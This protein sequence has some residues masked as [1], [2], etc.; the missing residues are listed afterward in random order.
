MTTVEISNGV[1][2][3]RLFVICYS[4]D[5]ARSDCKKIPVITRHHTNGWSMLGRR[6]N[7]AAGQH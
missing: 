7:Y 6:H 3:C 1:L 2:H 4:G 5:E